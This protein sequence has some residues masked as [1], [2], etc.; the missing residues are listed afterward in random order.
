MWK[1]SNSKFGTACRCMMVDRPGHSCGL[2]SCCV[3]YVQHAVICI[4]QGS[5]Q[6][7][8]SVTWCKAG[9]S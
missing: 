1:E 3:L 7:E 9:T 5:L 4:E 6:P 2:C 8:C